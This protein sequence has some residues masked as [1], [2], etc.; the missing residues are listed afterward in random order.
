[1]LAKVQNDS[2]FEEQNQQYCFSVSSQG[3]PDIYD[4]EVSISAEAYLP[5]DDNMIP[6]GSS[7]FP[8]IIFKQNNLCFCAF[9]NSV[10]L[11]FQ[12]M[13]KHNVC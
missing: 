13:Q 10:L 12:A 7:L 1:M 11:H 9:Y 2:Y 3:A 5:V 8:V 4:H 6:T